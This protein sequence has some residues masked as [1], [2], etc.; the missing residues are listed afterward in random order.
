MI[1]GSRSVLGVIDDV[2]DDDAIDFVFGRGCLCLDDEGNLKAPKPESM[3]LDERDHR[4]MYRV[5]ILEGDLPIVRAAPV[6]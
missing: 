2:D 5:R 4:H 1:F 3:E 6:L